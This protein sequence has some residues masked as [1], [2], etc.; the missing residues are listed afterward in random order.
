MLLNLRGYQHKN[1]ALVYQRSNL[2]DKA[3]EKLVSAEKDFK[4]VLDAE[5]KD[6][7]A[8]NGMGSVLITRGDFG[9]AEGYIRKALDIAPD[10]QAARHDLKIIESWQ[11]ARP[12]E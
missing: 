5:P 4:K 7:S 12:P 11:E 9:Q 6:P 2:K 10:Y 3:T 8:L 1:W